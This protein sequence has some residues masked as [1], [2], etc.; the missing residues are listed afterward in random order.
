MPNETDKDVVAARAPAAPPTERRRYNR[1]HSPESGVAPPYYATF[2]R[3]A[4]AL[5][6]IERL[7][8]DK[9]MITLPESTAGDR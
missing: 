4:V 3:M 6:E 2:E 1:R 8:H 5:E 7:I 9:Q